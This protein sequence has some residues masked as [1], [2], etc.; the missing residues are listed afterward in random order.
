ME[1]K[2]VISTAKETDSILVPVETVNVD[3]AGEFV[4]IVKEGILVRQ[5][6]VTGLSSDTMIQIVEGLTEGDQIVTNVT[7]GLTE[8]MTVTAIPTN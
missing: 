5:S 7:T 4:Y 3:M 2:V 6:V 8:G 1:A